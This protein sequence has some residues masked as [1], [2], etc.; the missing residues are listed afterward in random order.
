MLSSIK[1]CLP[2]KVVFQWRS[3]S[4]EGCLTSKVNLSSIEGGYPSKVVFHI[5]WLYLTLWSLISNSSL[6]KLKLMNGFYIPKIF[7]GS[8]NCIVYR[9]PQF[10]LW[11]SF[12]TCNFFNGRGAGSSKDSL[13]NLSPMKVCNFLVGSELLSMALVSQASMI[14][15]HQG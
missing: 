11:L 3:S 2:L 9:Y 6:R 1:G 7:W 15:C 5:P 13:S 4:I 8:K 10:F 14:N 12:G